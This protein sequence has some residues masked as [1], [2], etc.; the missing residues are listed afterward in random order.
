MGKKASLI[1]KYGEYLKQAKWR[2][3]PGPWIGFSIAFAVGIGVIVG[4]LL[5]LGIETPLNTMEKGLIVAVVMLSLLDIML[6]YPYY[7]ATKRIARIEE[8]LPDALKQI[9]DTLKAGGTFEYGLRSVTTTETG[10]LAEEMETILF[11]L[12][13]G[14]NL[15]TAMRSFARG[16][17]S[18]LVDRAVDIMLD[19]IAAGASLAKILD[20]IADD[21]K[22]AHRINVERKTSTMMQVIF[23]VAAGAVVAPLIFGLV[24]TVMHFLITVSVKSAVVEAAKAA[25]AVNEGNWIKFMMQL[26]IGVEVV[27]VSAMI[28][29]MREG[30]VSKTIIYLPIL[31]SIAYI[32]YFAGMLGS[33]SMFQ[34]GGVL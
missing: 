34:M 21:I 31:L 11:K 10:P 8:D 12:E 29:M 32:C 20:E 19:S 30:N 24:S 16:I 28:S 4:A 18:R 25:A 7:V 17:K 1:E 23:M 14:E 6:G 22:A 15:E 9:A 13:E 2:I 5:F 26:Y 33:M 3:K 27:A